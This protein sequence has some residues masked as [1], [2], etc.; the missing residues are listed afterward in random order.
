M[1]ARQHRRCGPYAGQPHPAGSAVAHCQGGEIERISELGEIRIICHGHAA[2]ET[3]ASTDW[4]HST[5][6]R[7]AAA[8]RLA[9]SISINPTPLDVIPADGA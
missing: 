8:A 9:S 1:A 4:E 6:K 5:D 2:A 7:S 3:A